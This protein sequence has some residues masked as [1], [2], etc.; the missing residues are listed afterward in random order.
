MDSSDV[1]SMQ[2]LFELDADGNPTVVAGVPPDY[3]AV[4][5]QRWGNPLY[6][7]REHQR[8]GYDWWSRRFKR[9]L[10]L[11]DMVRIDHFRGFEAY[12]EIPANLPDARI[13]A[14]K[15]GPRDDFFL[16]L[17]R[18]LGNALP[19]IAEDLGFITKEVRDLRDRFAFPGMKIIQ[20]GF[21]EGKSTSLDL[22]H[23]YPVH[24]VAYTGTH[25]ND[26]TVGWFNS[27]AG[28][29]STRS[30]KDIDIEK[31][32]ALQ[33]L[34]CEPSQIHLGMMRA[35]WSSVACIA[36]APVQDLLGLPSRARMNT[37]GI[38]SGNWTWRCEPNALT[39]D[40]ASQLR[41]MT[42]SFGRSK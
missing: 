41:E 13:G 42:E 2:N 4:L 27:Q 1:W 23:N 17:Q 37:P 6:D 16:A 28:E 8:T 32:F 15:P 31:S 11:C 5:G 33:Y 39:S 19:V 25:D 10:Q 38:A 36:I 9:M 21:G 29:G 24:C 12:W 3:F 22:P 18:S 20:F 35:I 40:V 26:T 14:W 30:Q 7:W 34:H